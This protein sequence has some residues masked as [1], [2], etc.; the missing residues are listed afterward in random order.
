MAVDTVIVEAC[1]N[2]Q[3]E[4]PREERAQVAYPKFDKRRK[5]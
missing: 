4:D 5:R 2:G 3:V 1:I